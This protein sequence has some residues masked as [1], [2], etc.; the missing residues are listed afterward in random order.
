MGSPDVSVIIPTYNRCSFL[1][2]AVESCFEGNDTLDVEV[3]V[4]D[5]GSTDGTREWL[6]WR[7]DERIRPVFREHKG[8]QQARN[9]GMKTARGD[10][11]KFLDSDDYLYPGVLEEQYQALTAAEADVCYGPIDIVDGNGNK[12]GHKPN[13]GVEDLLG[14][15]ATGTVTTYPHVFLYRAEVARWTQ[16]RPEVPFHQDTAYALDVAAH[17][18]EIVRSEAAVGIHRAHSGT[19]ITTTTK[20]KSSRENIAYKFDLLYRALQKRIQC[21]DSVTEEV[22]RKV[23]HG[24]WQEAHKI[25]PVRFNRFLDCWE[26]IRDVVPGYYPKRENAILGSLDKILGVVNTEKAIN[27]VRLSKSKILKK[28]YR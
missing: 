25:G 6:R 13:P 19:R 18:P 3:V 2:E 1:P 4:V 23:A 12:Q 7:E 20:A 28:V 8:A 27:P 22:R 9:A 17:D 21:A 24:L 26:K 16:W 11:I 14:G 5:D 15:I 10:T